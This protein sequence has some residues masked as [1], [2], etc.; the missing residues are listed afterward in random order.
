MSDVNKCEKFR[1]Y[2]D[3]DTRIL[4][5]IYNRNITVMALI[6]KKL[7]FMAH[8]ITISKRI[9]Q[10]NQEGFIK[11]ISNTNPICIKPDYDKEVIIKDMINKLKIK[12][13]LI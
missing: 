2:D 5:L 11:I 1:S 12:W 8:R 3:L 10:L 4:D 6:T 7:V 9:K 13:R